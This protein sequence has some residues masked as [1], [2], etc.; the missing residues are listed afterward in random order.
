MCGFSMILGVRTAR[1]RTSHHTVTAE[2]RQGRLRYLPGPC[3]PLT[4][5]HKKRI[6]DTHEYACRTLHNHNLS[7]QTLNCLGGRFQTKQVYRPSKD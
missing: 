5:T 4:H 3:G 1:E 7:K 6:M 2:G